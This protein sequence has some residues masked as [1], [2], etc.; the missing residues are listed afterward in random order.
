MLAAIGQ[1]AFVPVVRASSG[2][3]A[4]AACRALA[5]GGCEVLE[6]TLTTPDALAAIAEL[7]AAGLVVGA[8]TVLAADQGAAAL[9]AGAAFLVSPHLDL[10]LLALGASTD[11]LVIPGALTPSEVLA[12]HRAGATLIKVFPVAALGGP[13]YL[14][15]LRDPLPFLHLFPTGGVT[16]AE[17]PAYL[18]NGAIAVGVGSELAHPE[19]IERGDVAS[20]AATARLFRT[21]LTRS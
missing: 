15:L 20:L 19:A 13:R 9:A 11:R 10:G 16:L 6:I 3:R 17:S 18:A 14:K 1:A 21:T 12:A 5:A 8:G 4:L 7:T 2:A